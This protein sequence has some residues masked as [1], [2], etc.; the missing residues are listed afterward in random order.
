M[1]RPPPSST[2]TD[3][4][5]P[6]TTL[7]RSLLDKYATYDDRQTY[8]LPV[9]F[10]TIQ[11]QDFSADFPIILTSGRLVEY[12]GGGDETRSNPWLA[13]LQQNMFVEINPVD[14]NNNG[15]R[16]GE[17]VWVHSREGS[18]VQVMAMVTARESG[19]ASCRDS[20]GQYV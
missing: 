10:K 18:K 16:D 8:R 9:L 1:R 5:C 7:F 4:L 17:M 2:R 14:A 3:T 6:Y 11:Q 12:E 20:V 13:E 19:R 15:V